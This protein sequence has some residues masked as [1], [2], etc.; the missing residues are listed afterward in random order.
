MPVVAYYLGRP[1]DVWIAAMSGSAQATAA[2]PAAVNSRCPRRARELVARR[3]ALE[4]PSAP[5][6]T[7]VSTSP[8]KPGLATSPP[9]ST[10][11]R[12]PG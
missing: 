5:A 9:L 6:A 7:A 3:R 1:A 12:P 11:H 4:E 10:P 8:G 2:N